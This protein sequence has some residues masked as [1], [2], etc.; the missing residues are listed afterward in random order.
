MMVRATRGIGYEYHS[1]NLQD[2]RPVFHSGSARSLFRFVGSIAMS[3]LDFCENAV[4]VALASHYNPH[5]MTGLCKWV[6]VHVMV[7]MV[8]IRNKL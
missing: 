4:A 2:L 3:L 6:V 5:W 1:N 8:A 7:V